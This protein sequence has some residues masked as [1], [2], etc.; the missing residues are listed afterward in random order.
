MIYP[1]NSKKRSSIKS[2]YLEDAVRKQKKSVVTALLRNVAQPTIEMQLDC[3]SKTPDHP[4]EAKFLE[5]AKLLLENRR[6]LVEEKAK[7]DGE[8]AL[9]PAANEGSRSHM[10]Y[11]YSLVSDNE[12]QNVKGN[13][14]TLPRSTDFQRS[15]ITVL[16]N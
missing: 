4:E 5:L 13:T 15:G 11:F 7:P 16:V 6:Y 8:T 3:V 14:P 2:K 9:L 1:Q 10:E 12:T